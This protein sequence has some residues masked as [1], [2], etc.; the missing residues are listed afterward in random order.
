MPRTYIPKYYIIEGV[1][2]KLNDDRL[3]KLD[4]MLID[5][6]DNKMRPTDTARKHGFSVRQLASM[7][8][9]QRRRGLVVDVTEAWS[10]WK[11]C[12][13]K[14]MRSSRGGPSYKESVIS[15]IK[16]LHKQGYTQIEI[17]NTLG[18][19]KGTAWKY[20][21]GCVDYRGERAD[22]TEPYGGPHA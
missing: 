17:A 15:K 9:K 4:S 8:T 10:S 11:G 13:P 2:P 16:E 6:I 21:S 18:V 1:S 14:L 3:I 20:G 22:P 19:S 5:I 7:L 12:D